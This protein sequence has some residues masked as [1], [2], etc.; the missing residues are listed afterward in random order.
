[1]SSDGSA[2]KA[3]VIPEER[4]P[5]WRSWLLPASIVALAGFGA[6]GAGVKPS[7]L[8][9]K[10]AP[11]LAVLEVDRGDVDLVVTENGSLE[12]A[13]NATVRCEVEALIGLTGGAA[14]KAQGGR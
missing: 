12:S 5:P 4:R 2:P 7:R 1:M 6:W 13:D 9:S 11:T 14:G 3:L 8:W 10:T